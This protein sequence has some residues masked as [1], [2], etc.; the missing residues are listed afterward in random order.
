MYSP[1][2]FATRPFMPASCRTWAMLPAAPDCTIVGIG[3]SGG[4]LASIAFATSSEACVQI[5]TSS[6]LRSWCDSA[7]RR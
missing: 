2:G 7:P 4:K 1:F 5:L 6:S 3:L